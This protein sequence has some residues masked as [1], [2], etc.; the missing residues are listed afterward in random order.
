ME[1]LSSVIADDGGVFHR[2]MTLRK[3]LCWYNSAM[4]LFELKLVTFW[5]GQM[6][7]R[8]EVEHYKV[9]IIR[10]PVE[11]GDFNFVNHY[12]DTRKGHTQCVFL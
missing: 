3:K 8:D 9:S 7:E 10:N 12:M 1:P 4:S 6:F 5:F 11:H 2:Q